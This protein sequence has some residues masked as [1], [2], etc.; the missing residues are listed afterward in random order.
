MYYPGRFL[1]DSF[2]NR[3]PETNYH[4]IQHLSDKQKI[5]C[6]GIPFFRTVISYRLQLV[7][8]DPVIRIRTV[9]VLLNVYLTNV[10]VSDEQEKVSI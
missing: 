5:T 10:D 8:A 9:R 4:L 7:T 1:K 2:L 3:S 6:S